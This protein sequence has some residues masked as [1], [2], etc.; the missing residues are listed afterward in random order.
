MAPANQLPRPRRLPA[1]RDIALVVVLTFL[2]TYH[3]LPQIAALAQEGGGPRAA[4]GSSFTH[5]GRLIINEVPADGAYDFQF[6]LFD[7]SVGGVATHTMPPLLGVDVHNGLYSVLLDFGNAFDG[8]ATWLD[9]Q[10]KPSSGGA[11]VSLGRQQLTATPYAL[12]ARS[13]DWAGITNKPPGID[14]GDI[15]GVTAGAGLTGGGGSGEVTLAVVFGGD[16]TA[17]TVSRTDHTTSTRIGSVATPTCRVYRSGTWTRRERL[18]TPRRAES[19]SR[20]WSV[21][22]TLMVSGANPMG[23]A[24]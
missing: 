1:L 6:A 10:A 7:V 3:G 9:I 4:L 15:T 17:Q 11:Y 8:D 19:G 14:D 2:V 16:G 23:Q 20:R 12:Y 21:L 18:S 22:P 5:Q 13:T 24:E